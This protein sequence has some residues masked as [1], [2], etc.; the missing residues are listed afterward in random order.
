MEYEYLDEENGKVER[1]DSAKIQLLSRN[2]VVYSS[3]ESGDAITWYEAF[4][5]APAI[6]AAFSN[7]NDPVMQQLAGRI[8]GM[9]HGAASSIRTE[10][11]IDFLAATWKFLED[12][13][14]SYQTS[15]SF[16]IY[17]RFGQHVKYGRD[18]IQNRAG[19]CID[20]AILWA[21]VTRAVGLKPYIVI[22]SGH[23][24]PVIELPNGERL[25][26][27]ATLIGKSSLKDAVTEGQ[28][29]L[30][31]AQSM[32]YYMVDVTKLQAEGVRCLDLERVSDDFLSNSQFRFE[33]LPRSDANSQPSAQDQQAQSQQPSNQRDIDQRLV[34]IWRATCHINGREIKYAIRLTE[35]GGYGAAVRAYQNGR[36]V[37]EE[38]DRGWFSVD[39]DTIVMDSQQEGV[40]YFYPYRWR[41]DG[42]LIVYDSD[43]DVNLV[44]YRGD[45]D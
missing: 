9:A 39:G 43:L 13:N 4:E 14:F 40:R 18:V 19:T 22:R 29:Q 44:F 32:P 16:E 15:P 10:D 7:A 5:N 12:N 17:N 21:S 6:L 38:I 33:K 11:A 20:L 31:E 27:E 25:P 23:A 42:T 45:E 37:A 30:E 41:Q 28:K 35:K 26:I 34:G 8:S 36:K 2:E 3:R 1:T 24:F